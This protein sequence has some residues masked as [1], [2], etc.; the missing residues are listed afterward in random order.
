[1]HA[2]PPSPQVTADDAAQVEPEQQPLG[3][4]VVLQS[5][6]TPPAQIRPAQSW[7]AAPP[8]PHELLAVPV[9][10]AVPEQQPLGHDVRSQTHAPLTQRWP[11]PHGAPVP[12]W[13]APAAEHRSEAAPQLMQALPELPQL[14]AAAVL[15]V[16]P[17]QHPPLHESVSQMHAPPT[18]RWPAAQEAPAPHEQAPVDEQP[19][20]TAGSQVMQAAPAGPQRDSERDTQVAPSQ[21]PPGHD[22][23]LQ[24][25]LPPTQ[26]WAELHAGEVPHEQT[27]VAEQLSAR[28]AS[29]PMQTVP[30]LPQLVTDGALQTA[31]AQQPVGQLVALQP[32]QCPAVQVWPAG[33]AVQAPPPPPHELTLSPLRHTPAEQHPFGQE[34]PSQTQVLPA[35]RCPGAQVA[36]VPQRQAPSAEQLSDRASQARQLAPALPQVATERVEQMAPLQQPPGQD[37]ASQTQSPPLQRWPPAHAADAPHAQLPSGAQRSA[38]VV[39]HGRQTAPLAPQ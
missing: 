19:S 30:P 3:Q 36:P 26:R 23:A 21:Q 5:L 18:Q 27:P 16:V 14:A 15:H 1:M 22:A 10:Q 9:R 38:L 28:V 32:L 6:Q 34:V 12:H 39:S 4:F 24:T 29:Q 37:V 7:Q 20:A 35:Q 33:Q 11:A 13:Q 2:A 25:H 17:L 31:P 8:A